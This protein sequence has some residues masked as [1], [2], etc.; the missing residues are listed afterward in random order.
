[1]QLNTNNLIILKISEFIIKKSLHKINFNLNDN[2]LVETPVR[3]S[4][5]DTS[6]PNDNKN[7]QYSL[8]KN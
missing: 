1:M 3:R 6:F 4:Y 7:Q 5:E 2:F 8:I